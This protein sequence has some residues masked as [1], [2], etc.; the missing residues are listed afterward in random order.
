MEKVLSSII[1]ETKWDLQRQLSDIIIEIGDAPEFGFTFGVKRDNNKIIFANW[2]DTIQPELTKRKFSEFITIRESMLL[3]FSTTLQEESI[4]EV[5]NLFVNIMALTYL[6]K[7]YEGKSF[8]SEFQILKAKILYPPDKDPM[9]SFY[10]IA[11]IDS[12]L[13][14][15][16]NQNITYKLIFNTFMHFIEDIPY[17][18][19]DSEELIND[20]SRY[21]SSSPEEMVAPIQFK[22]STIIVINELINIGHNSTAVA[23]GRNLQMNH[24]TVTKHLTKIVSRYNASWRKELNWQALGLHTYLLLIKLDKNKVSER[25]ELAKDLL[26][27]RYIFELFDG[28]DNDYNY[29]YSVIHCPHSIID[30]L[31]FRLDKFVNDKMI[32][33]FELKPIQNKL[34]RTSFVHPKIKPTISNFDKLINN[35]LPIQKFILWNSKEKFSSESKEEIVFDQRLLEFLSILISKS[36]I[37]KGYYGVWMSELNAF[38]LNNNIDPN[39]TLEATNFFNKLQNEAL[40]KGLLDYRISISPSIL[41]SHDQLMIILKCDPNSDSIIRLVDSLSVFGWIVILNS[42]EELYLSINGLNYKDS[43]S[44]LISKILEEKEIEFSMLSI[45][46]CLLRYVPYIDLYDFEKKKWIL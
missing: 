37:T 24:S 43:T 28:E 5:S 8:E 29:L 30:N 27:N 15:I 26:K 39:D 20:F 1:E 9:T 11:E 34:Y 33:S 21:L 44:D 23:I 36:I 38:L 2:L 3:F 10:P 12:L 42:Y 35:K 7:K 46:S 17:E 40:E 14:T 4:L 22:D 25:E 45:K 18:A 41:N 16:V 6:Q 13:T 19:I 31:S 32:F